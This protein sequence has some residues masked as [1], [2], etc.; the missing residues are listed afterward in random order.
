VKP[1]AAN[2]KTRTQQNDNEEKS[3]YY[4]VLLSYIILFCCSQMQMLA[5]VT[6][7]VNNVKS[8]SPLTGGGLLSDGCDRRYDDE[9][10]STI[11]DVTWPEMDGHLRDL[12]EIHDPGFYK[13]SLDYSSTTE[14][15]GILS[16][17]S[18]T[19]LDQDASREDDVDAAAEYIAEIVE[20]KLQLANRRAEIDELTT[21]LNKCMVDNEA[22][23]AERSVLF[24]EIAQYKQ[25][26]LDGSIS[27]PSSTP[28]FRS[29]M[30]SI[31]RR[32]N[33]HSKNGSIKM[34]LES[35]SQLLLQNS[36]L[37]IENDALRKTLQTN[38]LGNRQKRRDDQETISN[39]KL[40][41]D[42]VRASFTTMGK[43]AHETL[44][45]SSPMPV[46]E[47]WPDLN[48]SHLDGVGSETS[49][50]ASEAWAERRNRRLKRMNNE[51]TSS[52]SI[53]SMRS[54][55]CECESHAHTHA[56]QGWDHFLNLEAPDPDKKRYDSVTEDQDCNDF[57]LFSGIDV[58][59]SWPYGVRPSLIDKKYSPKNLGKRH[60]SKY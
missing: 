40:E 35:N 12:A 57:N 59:H 53:Q 41:I 36:Q 3:T 18:S 38:I 43:I 45:I 6:V 39:L 7:T 48:D 50:H 17:V 42:H 54:P 15:T 32:K 46:P 44:S 56:D 28:S 26:S 20:L 22:L 31:G 49:P 21:R 4:L 5:A 13:L 52:D 23:V 2:V 55:K 1:V 16:M 30:L 14:S 51:T 33:D 29:N 9:D 24:D 58:E 25:S 8:S 10:E 27:S 11:S 60:S 19:H 47:H 34:L 37:Q